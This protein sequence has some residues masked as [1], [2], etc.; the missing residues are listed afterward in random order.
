MSL[1][2][3][4]C[5]FYKRKLIVIYL[6]EHSI[7]NFIDVHYKNKECIKIIIKEIVLFF[8]TPLVIG[9]LLAAYVKNME[10]K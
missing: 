1:K 3:N 7:L 9:I 2:V 4:H 8:K 6:T 10:N 5:H